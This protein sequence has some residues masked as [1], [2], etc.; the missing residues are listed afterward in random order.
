MMKISEV[1]QDDANMMEGKVK[2]PIYV[3]DENGKYTTGFSVGWEAKNAVMQNAWDDINEKVAKIKRQVLNGEV[4]PILYYKVF[5]LPLF[6]P[7]RE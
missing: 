2:E 1:P 3:L 4:S 5:L 7:C 6:V